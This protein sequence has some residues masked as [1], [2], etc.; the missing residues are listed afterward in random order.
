[1]SSGI[2]REY[3]GFV[4]LLSGLGRLSLYC[5]PSSVALLLFARPVKEGQKGQKIVQNQRGPQEYQWGVPP[6]ELMTPSDF[7][8]VSREVVWSYQPLFYVP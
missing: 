6:I 3:S 7:T 4:G 2:A 8:T 1:M 5:L